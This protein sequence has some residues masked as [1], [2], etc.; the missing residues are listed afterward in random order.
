VRVLIAHSFYRTSGGEDGCVRQQVDLLSRN[1]EVLLLDKHNRDLREGSSTAIRMLYS[2]RVRRETERAIRAFRPDVIH[3][4]NSYPALG[5]AVFLAAKRLEIPLVMTI[6][7]YRL[8]CPNGYMFTAG[9]QCNRCEGGGYHNAVIHPCFATKQQGFAY[10]SSLWSHRFLLN[11]EDLVSLF[12][13]PSEFMRTELQ[14]WGIPTEKVRRIRN[15]TDPPPDVD[16]TPG[17]YGVYV[18]RLSSEKGLYVLLDAL[19]IAGD[20]AFR[21]LGDG[22]ESDGLRQSASRLGLVNISFEGRVPAERVDQALRGSRFVVLPSIWN[23]NAPLAMLEAMARGRAAIVSAVGGLRELAQGGRGHTTRVGDVL[24][25]ARSIS[26]LV[27]DGKLCRT[28][29][30]RALA[31]ARQELTPERHLT[32]LEHAYR[33]LTA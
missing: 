11:L 13:C 33:S 14:R 16:L 29:G 8:R 31:F 22:P 23:E 24:D 2:Q 17:D 6:H 12:V 21:I 4:H 19:R 10:A 1:H 27:R 5:P 9:Q 32:Q 3:L 15:F 25:L 7:N 30:A 20:P 26:L 28:T 18:G